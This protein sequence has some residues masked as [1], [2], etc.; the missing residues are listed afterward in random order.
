MSMPLHEQMRLLSM[1][2]IFVALSPEEF[3]ELSQRA[4]DTFLEPGEVFLLPQEEGERLYVL[5]K[6]ACAGLLDGSERRGDNAL[7]NRRGQHIRGDGPHW[8]AALEGLRA[9]SGAFRGLLAQASGHRAYHPEH[10]F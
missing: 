9:G 6:G 10:P 4:P 2:E 1:V 7:R 3:K 8:P 5:K